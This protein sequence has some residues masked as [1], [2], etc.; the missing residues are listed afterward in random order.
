MDTQ[1]NQSKGATNALVIKRRSAVLPILGAVT[2]VLILA[3]ILIPG[4]I[5]AAW[6]VMKL[7]RW[8]VSMRSRTLNSDTQQ[9]IRQRDSAAISRC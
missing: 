8:K 2:A 9:R 5:I 6:R 4:Q 1:S 7:V 3:A